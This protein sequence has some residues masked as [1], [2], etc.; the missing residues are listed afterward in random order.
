[1]EKMKIKVLGMFENRGGSMI[2]L[3]GFMTQVFCVHASMPILV[4][5]FLKY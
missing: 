1:M 2:W 4:T 3:E 5:Q